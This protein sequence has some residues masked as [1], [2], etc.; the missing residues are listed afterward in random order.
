MTKQEVNAA[1]HLGKLPATHEWYGGFLVLFYCLCFS[2]IGIV[3]IFDKPLNPFAPAG[4]LLWVSLSL[5]TLYCLLTERKLTAV[6]TYLSAGDN[7]Q[8]IISVFNALNW[9]VSL[10]FQHSIIATRG[11]NWFGIPVYA[12]ALL[13]EGIVYLNLMNGGGNIKGRIPFSF[14]QNEQKLR[15]LID[16]I[17]KSR[18]LAK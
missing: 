6:K 15:L 8:L 4:L 10:P 14:G 7:Q 1:I 11:S 2:V 9:Q 18:Q 3:F 16:E 13:E 17:N 5:Y 12:T